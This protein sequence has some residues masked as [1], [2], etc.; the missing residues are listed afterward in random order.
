MAL[1]KGESKHEY[2]QNF[3]FFKCS[4]SKSKSHKKEN[5]LHRASNNNNNNSNNKV[6]FYI[7]WFLNMMSTALYILN[8]GR[9]GWGDGRTEIEKC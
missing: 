4:S 2:F 3:C 8:N 9:V 1:Y 5:G 6:D 7:A